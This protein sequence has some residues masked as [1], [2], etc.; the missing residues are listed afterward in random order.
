[1]PSSR[2]IRKAIESRWNEFLS[3]YAN[4]Y[5]S[6]FVS[7]SSPPSVFVGSSNYP[8]VNVGPLVPPIHGNTSILDMP[9]QWVGKS[10]EDIVNYRL[11][12]VRGVQK[13]AVDK[14]Y[15][16]FV[17]T[18][19][20]MI[21]ASKP[22][23][24]ELKFN[25]PTIATIQIDDYSPPFG[26]IGEIK[27]LSV[28]NSSSHRNL[29]KI[30]YDHNLKAKDAII[31]LYQNDVSITHI[32]KCLSLGMLGIKRKIV[33]TKWSITATDDVISDTLVKEILNNPV[34]D[35]YRVFSFSHLGNLFSIVLF[36]HRWIFEMTEAWFSN[37]VL[38][39]GSDFEDARGIDHPPKIAGAYFAAKLAI[40]EYLSKNQIQSGVLVLRE[41]RPEYAVPVGVWQV[42]EGIREAMKNNFTIAENFDNALEIAT[43]KMSIS[44]KE[45]LKHGNMNLLQKQ[46]TLTDF[47]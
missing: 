25:K 10:L 34:L 33:P 35:E 9:E 14:P 16:R 3:Q 18:L 30:Y 42:R 40:A 37:G 19:Q 44:S 38:G 8:K 7:G 20:E 29:E 27:S 36:P 46:K 5:S 21:L 28:E 6:D 39:F 12:L 24:S 43:I 2:E 4:L 11:C 32:Q 1:M 15:G 41:I 26:P 22:V 31:K 13:I 45:W 17:E 23:S 47:L